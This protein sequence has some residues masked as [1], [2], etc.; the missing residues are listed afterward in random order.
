[1]KH[2]F[3]LEGRVAIITGGYSHLGSS[4]VRAIAGMNAKVIVA[5]LDECKFES[6]FSDLCGINFIKCD[7]SSTQEINKLVQQVIT[8]YGQIDILINN[9]QST[10]ASSIESISDDD[11][12]YT[13]EGVLGSVHKCIRAIS[14]IMKQQNSGKIINISSMYGMVSPDF[15][16]YETIEEFINP[17]HYGAAKAGVIQLTKYYAAYLGKFNIQV[18]CI[19]PG[20]FPNQAVQNSSHL[21]IERLRKKT[22]LNRIGKPE[23]ICGA[24]VLLSSSAS[25][26]ITGHNLVVDG[27]WTAW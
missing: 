17:P 20:P 2:I 21:F 9:A 24:I 3:D 27:G 15:N 14:P 25:N 1:M 6:T 10:R 12:N 18:N 23:D 16:V 26:Y 7:I 5:G 8:Q 4:M 11:W 19:S 13:V 22:M